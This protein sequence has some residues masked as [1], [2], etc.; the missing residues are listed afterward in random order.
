MRKIF[1][2]ITVLFFIVLPSFATVEYTFDNMDSNSVKAGISKYILTKGGKVFHGESYELNTFQAIEQVRDKTYG[3]CT[4]NYLFNITPISNG[5][6]LKLTVLRNSYGS[7]GVQVDLTTEQQVMDKIKATIQGRFLYVLGFEFDYYD[8]QKGKV[9][10]PK[11]KQT[12]IV[13]TAVKYDARKKGL[14]VGDVIVEINGESIVDMPIEKYK[15]VLF[16]KSMTDTLTLTYKRNGKLATVT[17]MPRLS[18]HKT[19]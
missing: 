1:I 12:G 19:F 7:K 10:A 4:Y 14:M 17:I 3:L 5:S 8:T 2:L 15:T 11:G 18:N 9:K 16:A 6:K 13:L